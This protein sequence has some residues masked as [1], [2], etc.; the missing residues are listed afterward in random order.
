L[1]Q[2]SAEIAFKK[3]QHRRRPEDAGAEEEIRL[4]REEL[5]ALLERDE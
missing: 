2:L 1:H 3:V 5:I 4:L